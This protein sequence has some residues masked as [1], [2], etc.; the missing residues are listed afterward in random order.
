M[1]S[2]VTSYS[3]STAVPTNS[4]SLSVTAHSILTS[5]HEVTGTL[6]GSLPSITAILSLMFTCLCILCSGGWA[7]AGLGQ[8]EWGE[9]GLEGLS[10]AW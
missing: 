8:W 5:L 9:A 1:P 3:F 7:A 4:D 6:S 2:L 10:V